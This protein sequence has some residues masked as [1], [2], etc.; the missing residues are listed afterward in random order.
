MELE[1]GCDGKRCATVISPSLF[2]NGKPYILALLQRVLSCLD[3]SPTLMT[4]VFLQ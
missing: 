2:T 1:L 4:S 3:T